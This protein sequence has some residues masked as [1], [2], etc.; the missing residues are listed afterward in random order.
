MAEE[1]QG[2]R[3]LASDKAMLGRI[4]AWGEI[5]TMRRTVER[6]LIEAVE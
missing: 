3:E 6:E 4:E 5:G 1:S 2:G